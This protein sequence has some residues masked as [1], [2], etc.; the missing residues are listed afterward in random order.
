MNETANHPVRTAEETLWLIETVET[1]Q[2]LR[3]TELED[4]VPVIAD[5]D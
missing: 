5:D 4:R 2:G 3:L 1:D